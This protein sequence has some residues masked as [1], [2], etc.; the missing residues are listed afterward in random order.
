M[1]ADLSLNRAEKEAEEILDTVWTTIAGHRAIPVD[2]IEISVALGVDVFDAEMKEGVSGMLRKRPNADPIIYLNRSDHVNRARFTCAHELGHYV[3][4]QQ[5]EDNR[6]Y[7]YIDRRDDLSSKGRD[8][9]E[10]FANRFAAALLM[11]RRE[12]EQALSAELSVMT[13]AFRFK[14]SPEAMKNRLNTLQL[15]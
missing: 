6:K 3:L 8:P 14:V 11:P 13:L 5:Q 12:L 1:T 2:P 7:Q 4:R 15:A 10:M 9:V